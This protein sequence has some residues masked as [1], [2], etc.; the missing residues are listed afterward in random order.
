[1]CSFLHPG[2]EEQDRV[3]LDETLGAQE[4]EIGVWQTMHEQ[5]QTGLQVTTTSLRL[6]N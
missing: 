6:N 2:E 5:E 4:E 3:M 1:M